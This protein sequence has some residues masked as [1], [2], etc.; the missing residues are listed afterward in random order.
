[1][2]AG[3]TFYSVIPGLIRN[4]EFYCVVFRQASAK[5]EARLKSDRG[6]NK[7]PLQFVYPILDSRIRGNDKKEHRNVKK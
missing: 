2:G 6:T 7:F 4:P 1:M 5:S 3:V